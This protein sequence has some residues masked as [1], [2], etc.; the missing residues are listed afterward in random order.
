MDYH[1][2]CASI[3]PND[4]LTMS[5]PSAIISKLTRVSRRSTWIVDKAW[6]EATLLEVRYELRGHLGCT[7]ATESDLTWIP[8][9]FEDV[10]LHARVKVTGT[11]ASYHFKHT[12][13]KSDRALLIYEVSQNGMCPHLCDSV[14]PKCHLHPSVLSLTSDLPVNLKVPAVWMYNTILRQIDHRIEKY[15]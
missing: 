6:V 13:Y 11:G 9:S 3:W 8:R 7:E 2:I 1:T 4:E 14:Q 15:L 10:L 12:G 5:L